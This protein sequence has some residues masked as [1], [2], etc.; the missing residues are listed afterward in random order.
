MLDFISI[1]LFFAVLIVGAAIKKYT[2]SKLKDIEGFAP[3]QIDD[4]L[5]LAGR[6]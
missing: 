1:A 4:E 3:V 2:K 5:N 6:F